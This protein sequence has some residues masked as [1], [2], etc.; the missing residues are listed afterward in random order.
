MT[1]ERPRRIAHLDMDAFYASVELLRY[2]ELRGRPV[3]IGGGRNAAPEMLA[4]GT[5]RF[6]RLRDYV[7][8]G[9]VTTSTYEARAFGVFSAMG[10]M[11]AAQLA[12]DAVL[13]PTDFDSYRRYSRLFKDAVLAFTDQIEDRGIDEIYI[14]LTDVE[15]ESRELG[16]RIKLA[17][18]QATGLTCSIAIAPNKL[19][20]KI[21]SELDKPN[22][23]TILTSADV[24]ARIWPLAAKKVNGIGPRASERLAGLGIDTIGDVAAADLGL[25]QEHFG[26]KYAAWLARI[27]H[28]HDE[29][30][31]VVSSE[32]KSMSR[33]TT[34]ERDM[35]VRRDRET[36]TPALS[37]L[38]ERVAQ[39]LERK[40]YC[41][42]TVG[43]KIKF[44][45]FKIVTRD[46]S[47][48]HAVTSA[49]E[50]RRA[51]G[52][53][54]KRIDLDRRIRLIG[55]RASSLARPQEG[56]FARLHAQA[57]LPFDEA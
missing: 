23:L 55:V 9:V 30:A 4:D 46:L 39:D 21:G 42:R 52:E 29:R 45:D 54:L 27:S 37:R 47:L 34:F 38:C 5:R 51:A 7:G 57:E 35:H 17:V 49:Q 33:E 53:C 10:M 28:G 16:E 15:G 14:D 6:A 44:A 11:K 1:G 13:L 41:A 18:N 50:I 48:P 43:I 3:V 12:P 40:G 56:E 26:Q 25:L 32:P 24:Q 36:L 22:G 8:R 2:P 31:V 20:A 19:L